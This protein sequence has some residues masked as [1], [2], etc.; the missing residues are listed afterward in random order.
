MFAHI[1]KKNKR[2]IA[3]RLMA[4]VGVKKPRSHGGFLWRN[5][6]AHAHRLKNTFDDVNKVLTHDSLLE[7]NG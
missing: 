1:A 6:N 5:T 7:A 3:H 4:L 2:V